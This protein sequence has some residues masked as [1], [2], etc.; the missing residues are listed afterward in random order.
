MKP[1][2]NRWVVTEGGIV[3]GYPFRQLTR[4]D[5]PPSGYETPILSHPCGQYRDGAWISG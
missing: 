5:P 2:P 3:E 4:P 1:S